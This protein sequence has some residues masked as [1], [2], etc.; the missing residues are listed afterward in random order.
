MVIDVTFIDLWL[1]FFTD[2][3]RVGYLIL[4]VTSSY[5]LA[6]FLNFYRMKKGHVK[7]SHF[8]ASLIL[9][10][11]YALTDYFVAL[12]FLSVQ[13]L[14]DFWGGF[15]GSYSIYTIVDF[16]T[17]T[18]I[19][20]TCSIFRK[21]KFTQRIPSSVY[22]ICFLLLINAFGHIYIFM[23]HQYFNTV[24]MNESRE[25]MYTFLSFL[26][27]FVVNINCFLMI[28]IVFYFNH[29][30]SAI[31]KGKRFIKS[32]CGLYCKGDMK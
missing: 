24:G 10:L 20:L 27:S 14:S 5:V 32:V 30:D 29:A 6:I 11:S 1:E 15:E 7:D 3:Q 23:I 9:G 8:F 18:A 12:L 4:F 22:M 13:S 31:R 25:T 21:H 17:I 2:S 16:F 26:Y 28:Y 19:I